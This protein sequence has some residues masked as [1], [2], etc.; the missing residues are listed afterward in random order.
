MPDWLDDEAAAF[1]ADVFDGP[2]GLARYTF[3][4]ERLGGGAA[5]F[6]FGLGVARVEPGAPKRRGAGDPRPGDNISFWQPVDAPAGVRDG[7]PSITLPVHEGDSVIDILALH[8]DEPWRFRSRTGMVDVLGS[9]PEFDHDPAEPVVIYPH[10]LAWLRGWAAWRK[11]RE[12]D[13]AEHLATD[14]DFAE[15]RPECRPRLLDRAFRMHHWP[16]QHGVCVLDRHGF[17][18]EAALAGVAMV[19]SPDPAFA[20]WLDKRLKSQ[21]TRRRRAEPPLPAVYRPARIAAGV[22]PGA[23]PMMEAVA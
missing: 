20:A 8:P 22:M 21:R 19:V 16:G 14:P 12:H 10:P 5:V 4:F 2:D 9:M 18:W 7:G 23:G 11:A 1:H 6:D 17:D 15:Y 3:L 13:L